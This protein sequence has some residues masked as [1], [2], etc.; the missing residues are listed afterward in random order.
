MSQ[1]ILYPKYFQDMIEQLIQVFIDNK[2]I[3]V[4]N[5]AKSTKI[6]NYIMRCGMVVI[7]VQLVGSFIMP[8]I[9]Q[10]VAQILL[11]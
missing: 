2:T 8:K 6:I 9:R 1:F 7:Q 4:D 10:F 3:L 11:E 5:M